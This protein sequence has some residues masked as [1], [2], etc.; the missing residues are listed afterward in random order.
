MEITKLQPVHSNDNTIEFNGGY[1]F[2]SYGNS[3]ILNPDNGTGIILSDELSEQIKS[4][5]IREA[6]WVKLIQRGLASMKD[7]MQCQCTERILPTFFIFDLTQACNFRCIYCFRHLED[8]VKTIS[9]DN[10]DAII[11][12][13]AD[14]CKSQ[15][16]KN[17]AFN[18]GAVNL[19]WL[20]IEYAIWS[21]VSTSRGCILLCQLKQ[22]AA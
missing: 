8:S 2:Q 21:N 12:Y 18:R 3:Y 1:C 22:M 11:D 14:Y 20:L 13:I 4:G 5:E 10:L 16:L 17:F 7:S 19:C 9:I 15:G 6:L